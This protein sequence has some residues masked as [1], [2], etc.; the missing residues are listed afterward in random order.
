LIVGLFQRIYLLLV[1]LV[2]ILHLPL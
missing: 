2:P 1:S